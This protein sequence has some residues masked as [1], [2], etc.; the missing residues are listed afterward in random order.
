MFSVIKGELF[1]YHLLQ[2]WK[3][4]AYI[5]IYVVP[6]HNIVTYRRKTKSELNC[7]KIVAIE[8]HERV[9]NVLIK[10][11]DFIAVWEKADSF[12]R[13]QWGFTNFTGLEMRAR[14][15]KWFSYF[16]LYSWEVRQAI[17]TER[18][19]EGCEQAQEIEGPFEQAFTSVFPRGGSLV[20]V[21]TVAAAKIA[22]VSVGYSSLLPSPSS[23]VATSSANFIY[24]CGQL[25]FQPRAHS[26]LFLF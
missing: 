5:L 20:S 23:S 17:G 14:K 21:P 24:T 9:C 12:R 25:R 6:Q 4:C 8:K 7:C 18:E 15:G 19:K 2:P 26:V 22:P 3:F 1:H 13:R 16:F 10:M 11:N